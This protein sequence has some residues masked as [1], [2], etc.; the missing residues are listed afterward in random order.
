MDRV[1]FATDMPF[2]TQGGAKYVEVA[3]QA[4]EEIDLTS[5]DKAR[6]YEQNAR[7]LFGLGGA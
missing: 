6:I 2:D 4:M 1:M 3:L 5:E 7:R